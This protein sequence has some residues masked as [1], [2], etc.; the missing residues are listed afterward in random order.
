M[1]HG[2]S[3]CAPFHRGPLVK[4]GVKTVFRRHEIRRVDTLQHD[5]RPS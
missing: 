5:L 3:V 4:Q 1:I 2:E